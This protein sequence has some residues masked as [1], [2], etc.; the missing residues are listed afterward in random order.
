VLPAEGGD[1]AVDFAILKPIAE[2]RF[3]ISPA[4]ISLH[5]DSA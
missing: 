5:F 2:C 4:R 3:G 1:E